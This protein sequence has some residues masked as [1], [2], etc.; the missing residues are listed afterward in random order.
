MISYLFFIYSKN[1]EVSAFINRCFLYHAD[2]T[3]FEGVAR[4]GGTERIMVSLAANKSWW[5]F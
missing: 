1:K 3:I 2:N 4:Q 5:H